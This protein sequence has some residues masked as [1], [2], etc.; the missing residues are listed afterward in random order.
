MAEGWHGWGLMWVSVVMAG[1][2]FGEGLVVGVGGLPGFSGVLGVLGAV[3]AL[4]IQGGF[5]PGSCLAAPW[6]IGAC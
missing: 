1:L 4:R 6:L 5:G 2:F 3:E